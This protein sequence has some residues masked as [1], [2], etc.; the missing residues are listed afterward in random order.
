V[1]L[2]YSA[3]IFLFKI[4]FIVLDVLTNKMQIF[5]SYYLQ[6]GA[7]N[8][9]VCKFLQFGL[10]PQLTLV[11]LSRNKKSEFHWKFDATCLNC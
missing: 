3:I 6:I 7:R 5:F 10:E 2:C 8:I 1:S 11:K 4:T 9:S